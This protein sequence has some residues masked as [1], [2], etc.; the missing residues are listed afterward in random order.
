MQLDIHFADLADAHVI[1]ASDSV[2]S[3][4]TVCGP[5]KDYPGDED[6]A[7]LEE[8]TRDVRAH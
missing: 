5:S 2:N 3:E 4:S 8:G 7:Q 6:L 1:L